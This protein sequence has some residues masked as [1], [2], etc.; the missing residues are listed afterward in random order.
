MIFFF[1]LI[2]EDQILELF[3]QSETIMPSDSHIN[4]LKNFILLMHQ[5]Y[6]SY[7]NVVSLYFTQPEAKIKL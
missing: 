6:N 2:S 4:K 1:F 3:S 7:D 5:N